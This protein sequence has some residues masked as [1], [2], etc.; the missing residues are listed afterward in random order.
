MHVFPYAGKIG[1]GDEAIAD[2][3][4][5]YFQAMFALT[6]SSHPSVLSESTSCIRTGYKE[7][8]KSI[9]KMLITRKWAL[10]RI[11]M[12]HND[13]VSQCTLYSMSSGFQH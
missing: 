5:Y 10:I 8:A 2:I 1:T 13:S 3:S 12:S 9:R 4:T 11:M 7:A 6:A